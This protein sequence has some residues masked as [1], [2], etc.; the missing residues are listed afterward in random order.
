MK[1][2]P[3]LL[4]RD[5]GFLCFFCALFLKFGSFVYE[6][7]DNDRSHNEIENIVLACQS[8]NNKKPHDSL[9]QEKAIEKL[10]QNKENNFMREKNSAV[11]E[12]KE[13]SAEIEINVTN[14]EIT[15]QYIAESIKTNGFIEYADALN[16]SVF[17]CK[18]KTG[19]G[20]QQSIRNYI[21][22]LTSTVGPFQ[23][24]RNICH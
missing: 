21:A 15:E 5:G 10:Q 14:S 13:V 7:L 20:S 19:H 11:D 3:L 2:F 9:M 18:T 8:C 24:T 17:V 1:Y 6:H 22:Y 23:I 16:S 4:Q 12:N